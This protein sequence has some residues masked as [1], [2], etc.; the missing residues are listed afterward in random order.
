MSNALITREKLDQMREREVEAVRA[1]EDAVAV[2]L[3]R[4]SAGKSSYFEVLQAQEELYPAQNALAQTELDRR[5]II[6]QLYEALGGGWKLTNG[7]WTTVPTSATV[8]NP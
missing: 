5:L 7:Q 1:Y 2:S 8:K 4:Y 3:E 6:V